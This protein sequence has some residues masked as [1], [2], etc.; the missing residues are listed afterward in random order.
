MPRQV[1]MLS[2]HLD[3]PVFC[4]SCPWEGTAVL[5]QGGV[6]RD[7]QDGIYK[8]HRFIHCGMTPNH[9]GVD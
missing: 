1:Q 3:N 4:P 6:I 7:E 5:L 2:K 9:R 8:M